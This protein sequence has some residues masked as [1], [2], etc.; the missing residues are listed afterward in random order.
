MNFSLFLEICEFR[1]TASIF[2]SPDKIPRLYI[3]YPIIETNKSNSNGT[4][5]ISGNSTETRKFGGII[6]APISVQLSENS[7]R[8]DSRLPL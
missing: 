1:P 4:G 8:K 2:E 6:I 3:S 7:Y 5:S